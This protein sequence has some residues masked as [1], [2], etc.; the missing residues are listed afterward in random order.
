MKQVHG[1]WFSYFT[2]S[3]KLNCKNIERTYFMIKFVTRILT[4]HILATFTNHTLQTMKEYYLFYNFTFM[5]KTDINIL[6]VNTYTGYH[7]K[8]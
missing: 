5:Y 8:T 1:N 3:T 4:R 7:G 2:K 6:T